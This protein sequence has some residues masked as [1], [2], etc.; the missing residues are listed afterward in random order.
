MIMSCSLGHGVDLPPCP[1]GHEGE[2][3]RK[4]LEVGGR[5]ILSPQF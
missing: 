5:R 2:R 4:M 1:D 3:D